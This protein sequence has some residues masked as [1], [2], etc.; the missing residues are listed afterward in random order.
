MK[1]AKGL[2]TAL[3][4]KTA[5]DAAIALRMVVLA[6]YAAKKKASPTVSSG[7]ACLPY[8]DTYLIMIF[9]VCISLLPL[10]VTTSM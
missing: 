8:S 6:A 9:W 2:S 1:L 10:S 4:V 7:N 3:L 5:A